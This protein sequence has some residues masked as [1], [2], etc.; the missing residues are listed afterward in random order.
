MA[1]GILLYLMLAVLLSGCGTGDSPEAALRELMQAAINADGLKMQERVCAA[2]Q[3]R[4]QSS[5][6]MIT[7]MNM[8]GSSL[9]GGNTKVQVDLSGVQ[10]DTVS[11][12]GNQAQVRMHG[13]IRSAILAMVQTQPI[14]VTLSVI[15]EDGKWKVCDPN[16]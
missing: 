1:L 9:L 3:Q 5:G 11:R 8:L 16:M 14:D 2:Q 13:Q 4:L 15:Q 7:M 12:N 6:M 10:Y